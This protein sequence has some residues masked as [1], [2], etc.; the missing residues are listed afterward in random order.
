LSIANIKHCQVPRLIVVGGK[1]IHHNPDSVVTMDAKIQI[2]RGTL[3]K[4]GI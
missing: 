4:L 1:A 2:F 3:L